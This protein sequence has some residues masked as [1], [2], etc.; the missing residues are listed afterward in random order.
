MWGINL[1]KA[2]FSTECHRTL[3]FT[4]LDLKMSDYLHIDGCQKYSEAY[5]PQRLLLEVPRASV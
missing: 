3:E 5:G 4:I 1:D 2:N